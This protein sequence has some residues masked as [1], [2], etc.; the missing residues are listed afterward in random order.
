ML[1]VFV[2]YLIWA[3]VSLVAG[4]KGGVN[5]AIYVICMGILFQLIKIVRIIGD[6]K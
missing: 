2:L 3:I 1:E 4:I 5:S 6:V